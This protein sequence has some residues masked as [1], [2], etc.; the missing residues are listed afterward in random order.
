MRAE[1]LLNNFDVFVEAPGG[2]DRLRELVLVL[3]TKGKLLKGSVRSTDPETGLPEDWMFKPFCEIAQFAMG[4]TPPTKNPD[5]W[6]G[7]N[8]TMWVS[9]GDMRDGQTI[10]ESSK[11]VSSKAEAEVFRREPWPTGT[12]LMSFKLTIGKMAR[13]GR[14]AFFNEA[15]FAFDAGNDTTNEYLF[16]ILPLISSS[17]DSKGAIKGNTLNSASISQMKIPIPTLGEQKRIIDKVDELMALCG[18]LES[19][20]KS[21]SELAERFARSVMNTV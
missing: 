20:L 19:V 14:P 1:T 18:Q 3:A 6:G 7:A 13:L 5:Y 15:I 21:R 9:I 2:I 16:R 4:K 12:L 10:N 11:T 8:S 17:A